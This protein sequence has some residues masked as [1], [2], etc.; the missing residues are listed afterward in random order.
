MSRLF[1]ATALI[2]VLLIESLGSALAMAPM[3]AEP[4]SEHSAMPCHDDAGSKAA[5]PCCD[6][7][8]ECRCSGAC[9]GAT[10]PLAPAVAV[11]PESP[12]Q[13]PDEI[14]APT[15]PSPAHRLRLL[16]PPASIES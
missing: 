6:E 14:G 16:R 8:D 12:A 11:L 10:S 3:I 1:R 5:M 9:F 13:L 7:P 4:A 15:S 2:C